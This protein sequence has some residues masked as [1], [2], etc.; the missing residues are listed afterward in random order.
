[1]AEQGQSMSASSETQVTAANLV[2]FPPEILNEILKN[3]LEDVDDPLSN[4][5]QFSRLR[6][7]CK[8]FDRSLLDALGL[9]SPVVQH[10]GLT[11]LDSTPLNGQ[12][13]LLILHATPKQGTLETFVCSEDAKATFRKLII[14]VP[15]VRELRFVVDAGHR[16]LAS[17]A[18][19]E[20]LI[21]RLYKD[22]K[23]EYSTDRSCYTGKTAYNSSTEP[24]CSHV[25]RRYV[26]TCNVTDKTL[27][28][29]LFVDEQAFQFKGNVT[30]GIIGSGVVS[31]L[32]VVDVFVSPGQG[33]NTI[34]KSALGK[35]R[36]E[37]QR[38]S[39]WSYIRN[40][41]EGYLLQGWLTVVDD[42]PHTSNRRS[43]RH[44]L[45]RCPGY[46]TLGDT[47]GLLCCNAKYR[48]R[49]W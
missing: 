43:W 32:K 11:Q 1:M 31:H 22:A 46:I 17:A 10:A 30:V 35:R 44:R 4:L 25:F 14:R 21:R 39:E 48:T 27:R 8:A 38:A 34:T 24:N 36:S 19:V 26:A 6:H 12:I 33:S 49:R 28:A 47:T 7:V 16:Y 2:H 15:R 18:E 9:R 5:E 40:V 37:E 45:L 23:L 41:K 29:T 3:V 13:S 42:P 20:V